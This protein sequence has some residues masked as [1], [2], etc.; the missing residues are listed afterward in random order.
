MNPEYTKQT[1]FWFNFLQVETGTWADKT[2]PKSTKISILEHMK[3]EIQELQIAIL[4]DDVNE[5]AKES[6]DVLLL[7]LHLG[8]KNETDIGAEA[9]FKLAINK[10]RTWATEPNEKGY[11]KHE[12]KADEQS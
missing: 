6:A 1:C 3:E 8:F 9:L 7:L 10:R 11:Y 2:F 5:I 4:N 12:E